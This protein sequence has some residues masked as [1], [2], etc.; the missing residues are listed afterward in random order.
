MRFSARCC[1]WRHA[2]QMH[3]PRALRRSHLRLSGRNR[4]LDP[5]PASPPNRSRA[6]SARTCSSF[7]VIAGHAT[8]RRS[9]KSKSSQRSRS[10]PQSRFDSYGRA[11]PRARTRRGRRSR[12]PGGGRPGARSL[13][14]GGAALAVDGSPTRGAVSSALPEMQVEADGPGTPLS[15]RDVGRL[16]APQPAP[17]QGAGARAPASGRVTCRSGLGGVPVYPRRGSSTTNVLPSP[18]LL[19]TRMVPPCASTIWRVM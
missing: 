3:R 18:G 15:I 8:P 14:W 5:V 16:R 17:N 10:T 19:D 9:P 13:I 2:R 4:R 6:K 7:D 11:R 12:A 1:F